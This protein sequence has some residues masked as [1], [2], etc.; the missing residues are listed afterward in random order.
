MRDDCEQ[1]KSFYNSFVNEIVC[2]TL[3]T[4]DLFCALQ[5][6]VLIADYF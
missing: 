3:E 1:V 5:L 6:L 2:D 4:Y